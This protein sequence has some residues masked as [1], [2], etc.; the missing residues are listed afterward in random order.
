[1]GTYQKRAMQIASIDG[2]IVIHCSSLLST[3]RK[4]C[5]ILTQT[6]YIFC[7][8]TWWISAHP[9]KEYVPKNAPH[10]YSVLREILQFLAAHDHQ[11]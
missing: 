6:S 11:Q 5:C 3:V 4:T 7:I 10:R 2:D 1:M 9:Y 8:V